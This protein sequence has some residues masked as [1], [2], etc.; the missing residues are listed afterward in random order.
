MLE[1]LLSLLFP[2]HC[3][4]CK[5]TGSSLCAIC[6]RTITT[7]PRAL[8]STVAALFDY[9]HPLVKKALW[10][11]KYHRKRSLGKYFGLA[12]YREFFKPLARKG[13]RRKGG[14]E[15]IVLVPVPASR[16]AV[17]MRGYNHAGIIAAA[18]QEAARGDGLTISLERTMLIKR[19]ENAR[20]VE[21]RTREER[22][23]NVEDIFFV[24]NGKKITG[25]TVVLIDDVI[26]TGATMGEARRAL[27]PW[28][29][30]RVLAVAVAH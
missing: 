11:L 20:Q 15:E 27:L 2:E 17:A 14:Q 1:D 22:K 29:P 28:K 13:Q 3:I 30:K 5:K 6:E 4:G 7:K 9:R 12:L 25:K 8:S 19:R 24:K 18:I 26:T 23:E 10:S 21:A 16:K